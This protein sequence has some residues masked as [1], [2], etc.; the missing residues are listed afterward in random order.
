MKK[1]AQPPSRTADQFVVRF[2]DGMR[3]RIAVA[4]KASGRSMNA[5]IIQRLDDS[6]EA[7][8]ASMSP[9]MKQMLD[10]LRKMQAELTALRV[11]LNR[12]PFGLVK[13]DAD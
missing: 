4:A 12:R 7:Q 11:Q 10:V 6:F 9:D 5:E 8:E 3:D 1:P 13:R 2:P